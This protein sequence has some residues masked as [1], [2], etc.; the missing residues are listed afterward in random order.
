GKVAF[1]TDANSGIDRATTLVLAKGRADVALCD[2]NLA[3]AEAVAQEIAALGSR[4]LALQ[5]DVA[6]LEEVEAAVARTQSELGRVD[7][8]LSN[9]G[10]GALVPFTEITETQ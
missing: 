7:I 1:I 9:A 3:G 4:A 10:I 5:I 2:V 8:L 6:H